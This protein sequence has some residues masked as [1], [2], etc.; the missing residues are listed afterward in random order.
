MKAASTVVAE[1]RGEWVRKAEGDFDAAR[2]LL[3]ARVQFPETIC[4][5]RQQSVEKYLNAYLVQHQIEFPKTHDLGM[6]LKLIGT[7]DQGVAHTLDPVKALTRYAVEE[8][9]PAD[10]STPTL[11]DAEAAFGVAK[12][13][14]SRIRERLKLGSD[15]ETPDLTP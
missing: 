14:R 9:Y 8:R 7:V 5:H 4:F 6:L 1:F 11:K 15:D 12:F 3:G 2:V 10:S 13:A